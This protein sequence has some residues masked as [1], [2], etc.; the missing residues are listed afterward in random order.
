MCI[1]GC[2]S[3][4]DKTEYATDSS[5]STY[6]SA[7]IR[8]DYLQRTRESQ[9]TQMEVKLEGIWYT[10]LQNTYQLDRMCDELSPL[11][12]GSEPTASS[13]HETASVS[14]SCTILD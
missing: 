8:E 12:L 7:L 2:L 4:C 5:S 1:K 9:G 14:A 13:K 10:Y 6:P 3:P 11:L